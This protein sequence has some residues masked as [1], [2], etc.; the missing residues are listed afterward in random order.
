MTTDIAKINM[1]G[2]VSR[3]SKAISL[4]LKQKAN[5][6]LDKKR[7]VGRDHLGN[8]YYEEQRPNHSRPLQRFHLKAKHPTNFDEL[9]DA[10]HVP[11]AWDAWLRF[12]RT[13]PPSEQEVLEGEEY[14]KIQQE[15]ANTKMNE[16]IQSTNKDKV[17]GPKQREV[18]AG[19]Y[20]KAR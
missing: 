13:E 15:M 3:W 8:E 14:F 7:L 11:P 20:K 12:R 2:T 9:I 5:F 16:S 18:P 1:S 10:C 6:K 4:M 19:Y 17:K